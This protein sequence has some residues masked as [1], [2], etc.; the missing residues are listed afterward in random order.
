[1]GQAPLY[2]GGVL[3]GKRRD[4]CSSLSFSSSLSLSPLFHLSLLVELRT[5]RQGAAE[6]SS[7][8]VGARVDTFGDRAL[9]RF[10]FQNIRREIRN[11]VKVKILIFHITDF[12]SNNSAL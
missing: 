9:A 2:I 7:S 12:V 6:R 4:S 11:P 5:G 10:V 8:P 1:M 3:R